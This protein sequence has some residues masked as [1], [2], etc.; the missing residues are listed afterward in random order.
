MQVKLENNTMKI[1][2]LLNESAIAYLYEASGELQHEVQNNSRV[3]TGQLK[4]SW[5]YEVNESNLESVIGSPL[6]NAIWEEFGTGEYAVNGDGRKGGWF[7]V[8]AKG[9]GHFTRGKSPQHAFQRAFETVKDALVRR[10]EK[11]FERVGE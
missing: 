3:D 4:G 7:Y 8:D 5:R 2:N 9:K 1:K 10:A 11:V 6:E